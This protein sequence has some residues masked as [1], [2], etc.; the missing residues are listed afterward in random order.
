MSSNGHYVILLPLKEKFES[1]FLSRQNT[2]KGFFAKRKTYHGFCLV[3]Q[4]ECII[5]YLA[6]KNVSRV[7]Y[8]IMHFAF[9]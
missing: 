8:C 6:L 5:I 7:N 9:L 4:P 1:K 3:I 2:K